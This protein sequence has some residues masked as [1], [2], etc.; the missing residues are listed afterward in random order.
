MGKLQMHQ[1][2]SHVNC[3]QRGR[4]LSEDA[5]RHVRKITHKLAHTCAAC[6]CRP[7]TARGRGPGPVLPLTLFQDRLMRRCI[8]PADW[9]TPFWPSLPGLRD[10]QVLCWASVAWYQAA[11]VAKR[12]LFFWINRIIG[13]W[14]LWSRPVIVSMCSEWHGMEL[15]EVISVRCCLWV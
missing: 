6:A 3:G 7:I 8:P 4:C 11:L 12:Q 15:Q 13:P 5:H 9:I 14:A 2:S 1:I 10:L